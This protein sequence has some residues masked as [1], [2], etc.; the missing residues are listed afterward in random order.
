MITNNTSKFRKGCLLCLIMA[1]LF[2]LHPALNFGQDPLEDYSTIHESCINS[3]YLINLLT[4]KGLPLNQD[5]SRE[6]L[7]LIN[8]G[9]IVGYSVHRN[10]PL[11]AAYCVS[12][13][14]EDVSYQ[15]PQFYYDDARL[16]VTS[17]V[18]T[19][20]FGSP[21][22]VGHMVPNNAINKQFGRLAQ[23]ETFLMSNMCPQR[24]NL[25][26]G[27]WQKLE[28]KIVD[29]YAQNRDYVWIICGP[30]FDA[31]PAT[32]TR[33]GGMKVEIASGFFMILADPTIYNYSV[34][35]GKVDFM[36]LKFPQ[37]PDPNSLDDQ[38]LITIDE[39]ETLTN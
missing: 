27:V 25:N 2:G 21:Y 10:Q 19:D 31:N 20:T 14:N 17:R 15:R 16:P 12:K 38:Y 32:I 9:Y 39:L 13:A 22:H 29:D 3:Q 11:W 5:S 1:L 4:Y 37:N 23:L 34:L 7:V 36:A 6:V 28:A 24:G 18:G 30:I 8:H 33:A 35:D 26:T